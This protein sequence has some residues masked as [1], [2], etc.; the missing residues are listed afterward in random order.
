MRTIEKV[1]I[2]RT[3][4]IFWPTGIFSVF[5]YAVCFLISV[6]FLILL[7]L[8]KTHLFYQKNAHSFFK[9]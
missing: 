2:M 4:R 8:P 5:W 1:I 9:T 6:N 7:F 3:N